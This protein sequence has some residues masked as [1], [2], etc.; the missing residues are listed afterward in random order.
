MIRNPLLHK[1]MVVAVLGLGISGM[2]AM[3]Y[4]HR[5]GC[6]VLVSDFRQ[7]DQLTAEE[8]QAISQYSA[9]IEFGG[10]SDEFL[11]QA[12]LIFKSPGIPRQLEVLQQRAQAGVPIMGELALAAPVLQCKVVAITGTNGKTT[13]TTLIGELLE[14]AGQKVGV[15]GNIGRPLLDCLSSGEEMDVAVVEVSSFQ[16]EDAGSFRPDVGV[17]LNITPDHLDR[18]ASIEEYIQAKAKLFSN[19]HEADIAVICGDDLICLE[20]A[21]QFIEIKPLLFGHLRENDAYIC[22]SDIYLRWRGQLEKY[23][24]SSS[25]LD[26]HIGRLNSAAAIMAARACGCEQ[27]VIE[28][29]L[30]SFKPLPH[31]MEL[32]DVIQGVRYC[33]DSKATNTGAVI[34]ALRQAKGN[35]V[36]IAGGKDKGDDYRL[37]RAVVGE[38]VKK[39]I[40]IGEAAEQIY[41]HLHDLVPTEFAD[42]LEQAVFMARDEAVYGDTVLLSPACASFDMFDSYGHRGQIFRESVQRLKIETTYGVVSG[43]GK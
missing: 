26:N 16:L 6:K 13:V 18:H 4:L 32:V 42:S 36:L 30:R 22:D 43:G 5:A 11:A 2:A 24:L 28:E 39:I 20:L 21:Q 34:S 33:N 15:C 10:H 41:E 19:Q 3:R 37:L 17:I 23:D 7:V 12:E 8:K 31:R 25:P 14:A 38:K 40:L 9:G 27:P 29:A 1:D 35:I